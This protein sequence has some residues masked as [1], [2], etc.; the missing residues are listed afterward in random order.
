MPRLTNNSLAGFSLSST[1]SLDTSLL[2]AVSFPS[3]VDHSS[4]SNANV[5]RR[6]LG[7]FSPSSSTAVISVVE[8]SSSSTVCFPAPLVVPASQCSLAGSSVRRL[9]VCCG[10]YIKQ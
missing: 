4:E 8:A 7:Y 10:A 1:N 6:L 9:L 2:T 3:T 5:F